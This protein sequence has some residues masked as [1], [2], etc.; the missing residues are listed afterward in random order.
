MVKIK[1]QNK[2][3]NKGFTFVE[4]MIVLALFAII[5]VSLFSSMA[6]G[7]KIWKR[8]GTSNFSHRKATL[9][10]ERLSAELRQTTNYSSIGFYGEKNHLEFP[11]IIRD[12]IL[13]ISYMY[14][15]Q[16]KCV[17]RV[18]TPKVP[19]GATQ[20]Q[21]VTRRAIVDVKDFALGFY[22]PSNETG[23]FTFLDSWNS[24]KSGIP[25]AV[26]V[27]LTLEDGK[28]FEKVITIPIAQ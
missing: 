15:P 10:L 25:L 11:N 16:E 21:N 20:E 13:N 17:I 19:A 1:N 12:K 18:S 23:N 8:A 2:T 6:M 5:G 9:S 22:G 27:S 26:K 3:I 4:T 24:T 14:V 28:G 7:L